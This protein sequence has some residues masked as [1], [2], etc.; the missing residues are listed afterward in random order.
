MPVIEAA[1]FTV[2]DVETARGAEHTENA[3]CQ[4]AIVRMTGLEIVDRWAGLVNPEMPIDPEMTAIHGID[5]Q[6]VRE[7]PTMANLMQSERVRTLLDDA[8][9]VAFNASFDRRFVPLTNRWLCSMR[10]LHHLD[11]GQDAYDLSSAAERWDVP[12]FR[13][14][15][16]DEDAL[17]AAL[18]TGKLIHRYSEQGAANDVDALLNFAEAP[19]RHEKVAFGQFKGA[20]YRTLPS[21]YLQWILT[22]SAMASD[23]D[24]AF[25]VRE[26][27]NERVDIVRETRSVRAASLSLRD[28]L[29]KKA[30]SLSL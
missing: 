4:L 8:T 7:A 26:T 24:I 29:A 6:A 5:D 22:G 3:A 13:A 27:L 9:P 2:V 21:D 1:R 30:A 20:A 18:L 19:I 16:A 28:R 12:L 25:T 14:H 17:A 10:L 15:D 23:P 11:P